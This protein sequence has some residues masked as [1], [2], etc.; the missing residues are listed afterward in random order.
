VIGGAAITRLG[1]TF[2]L[3]PVPIKVATTI[4]VSVLLNALFPWRRYPTSPT[5]I[6]PLA[7][8]AGDA[9]SHEAIL[10]AFRSI[11]SLVDISEQDIV[12]LHVMLLRPPASPGVQSDIAPS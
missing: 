4:A 9:P 11:E 1:Y 10:E 6:P 12:R 8:D 3:W 7:D 5:R 2:V